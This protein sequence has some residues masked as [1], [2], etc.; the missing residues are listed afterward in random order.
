MFSIFMQ[1]SSK[2]S[3]QW[4]DWKKKYEPIFQCI[5][6]PHVPTALILANW[7]GNL[8]SSSSIITPLFSFVQHYMLS[9]QMRHST[10]MIFGWH[11][12]AMYWKLKDWSKVSSLKISFTL[13]HLEIFMWWLAI[14]CLKFSY[15]L[16]LLDKYLHHRK[17][18][19]YS[20]SFSKNHNLTKIRKPNLEHK[21][22]R[23]FISILEFW[24]LLVPLV[25]DNVEVNIFSSI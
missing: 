4:K 17:Q 15:V 25:R 23:Y 24:I 7:L 21:K 6:H 5:P 18:M 1:I 3:N 16:E 10:S 14:L 22:M 2:K 12:S 8:F 13:I 20:F 19:S 11:I 9:P